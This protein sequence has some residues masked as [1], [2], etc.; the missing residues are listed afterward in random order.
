MGARRHRSTETALQLITEKISQ[1]QRVKYRHHTSS[2]R[3]PLLSKRREPHIWGFAESSLQ[4]PATQSLFVSIDEPPQPGPT[5]REVIDN[6]PNSAQLAGIASQALL[7]IPSDV[8]TSFPD[9]GTSR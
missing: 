7:Q 4:E 3:I 1:G 6:A 2:L 8:G 5:P 9:S